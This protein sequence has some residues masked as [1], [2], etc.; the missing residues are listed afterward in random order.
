MHTVGEWLAARR[1][2]THIQLAFLLLAGVGVVALWI[3][4]HANGLD[5]PEANF[6]RRVAVGIGASPSDT[7]VFLDI[8][9]WN[10]GGGPTLQIVLGQSKAGPKRTVPFRF[11]F[12]GFLLPPG[13]DNCSGERRTAHTCWYGDG[14]VT[15]FETDGPKTVVRGSFVTTGSTSIETSPLLGDARNGPYRSLYEEIGPLTP[16][17]KA[18]S[19]P[20]RGVEVEITTGV[21]STAA[22]YESFF[23]AQP[24]RLYPDGWAWLLPSPGSP[25][26]MQ[27]TDTDAEQQL[28]KRS[29]IRPLYGCPSR[30]LRS[31]RVRACTLE[32]TPEAALDA[33]DS[34]TSHDTSWTPV[35]PP[36]KSLIPR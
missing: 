10:E 25:I 7:R 21:G 9:P 23:P 34:P 12:E 5:R 22:R 32:T 11:E 31:S 16:P 14:T 6:A 18:L 36:S 26:G 33:G 15:D 35:T 8:E 20:A 28:R 24:Y 29:E 19:Y 27:I 13:A 3:P 1:S 30:A 2:E 17:S 4:W